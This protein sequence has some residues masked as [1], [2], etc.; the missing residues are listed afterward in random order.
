MTYLVAKTTLGAKFDAV[1][2]NVVFFPK[3]GCDVTLFF[4][5]MN[6]QALCVCPATPTQSSLLG[7]FTSL[8]SGSATTTSR[9]L[10]PNG[11]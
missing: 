4:V 9:Q 3:Y 6:L 5:R 1:K 11:K 10:G 7:L 8:S 2:N